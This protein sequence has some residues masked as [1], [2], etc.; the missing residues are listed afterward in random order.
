VLLGRTELGYVDP[1]LLVKE[2]Q[3]DR[4]L[5]LGGRSW[6]VTYIDW[7]RHRCFVEPADSG[8]RAPKRLAM[9]R[10]P[11]GSPTWTGLPEYS[12]SRYVFGQL[13]ARGL[14]LTTV[15]S[16]SVVRERYE[17]SPMAIALAAIV[18]GL[19]VAA[20]VQGVTVHEIGFGPLRIVFNQPLSSPSSPDS[21]VPP[22]SSTRPPDTPVGPTGTGVGPTDTGKP[23]PDKARTDAEVTSLRQVR[24]FYTAASIIRI[25]QDSS[26]QLWYH[27]FRRSDG[28]TITLSAHREGTD[29]VAYDEPKTTTQVRTEYRVNNTYFTR[30]TPHKVEL[31]EPVTGSE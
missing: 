24:V 25:C 8:G 31:H 5:L 10:W 19:L 2:V 12:P 20:L 3:G 28:A 6:R 7:R 14:T 18:G 27:G 13:P 17:V 22:P 16:L 30:S 9:A 15:S 23:C 11:Q 1:T 4:K 21:P 29:Y 26:G